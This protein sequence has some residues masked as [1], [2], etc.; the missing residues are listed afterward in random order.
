MTT[1]PATDRLL[2]ADLL[3]LLADPAGGLPDDRLVD[4]ALTSAALAELALAGSVRVDHVPSSHRSV[5]SATG[6]SAPSDPL[7]LP[8]WL[9][10]AMLPAAIDDIGDIVGSDLRH[11]VVDRL[12]ADGDLL[13]ARRDRRT[14]VAAGLRI[15]PSGRRAAVLGQV[16]TAL[17]G[18]HAAPR[19]AALAAL[20]AATG[21]LPSRE[22]EI[23]WTSE[24]AAAAR[25]LERADGDA[26]L[27]EIIDHLVARSWSA[28]LVAAGIRGAR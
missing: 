17:A 23:P 15:G 4:L 5:V 11:E 28:S 26:S 16:R 2:A 19:T 13:S 12:V 20:L 14:A 27:G 7:L 25:R 6:I 3:L 18:G 24:T 8:V 1:A 10:A 9:T 21:L 22:P